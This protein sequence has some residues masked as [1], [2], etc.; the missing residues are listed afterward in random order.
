MLKQFS[1]DRGKTHAV[2]FT[3]HDGRRPPPLPGPPPPTNTPSIEGSNH[4]PPPSGSKPYDSIPVPAVFALRSLPNTD[5]SHGRYSAPELTHLRHVT[6]HP[7]KQQKM[8][9]RSC[10]RVFV[11][12][13]GAVRGP[14]QWWAPHTAHPSQCKMQFWR[15]WSLC[16]L[17]HEG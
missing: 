8:A 17:S 11:H 5:G 9:E 1:P 4:A 2:S 10:H 13:S 3:S 6:K 12:T 7:E 16:A 14:S 15:K